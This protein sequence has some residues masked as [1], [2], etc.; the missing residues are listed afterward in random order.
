MDFGLPQQVKEAKE[1]TAEI[2]EEAYEPIEGK[3]LSGGLDGGFSLEV[4]LDIKKKII[5]AGLW[6]VEVPKSGAQGLGFLGRVAIEERVGGTIL[7]SIDLGGNGDL[8]IWIGSSAREHVKQY[9][10][11]VVEGIKDYEVIC[12]EPNIKDD[13]SNIEVKARETN[14]AINLEGERSIISTAHKKT[15]FIILLASLKENGEEKPVFYLVEP[16][17]K[18]LIISSERNLPLGFSMVKMSFDQCKIPAKN[19]LIKEEQV[20]GIIK[21]REC[22]RN[23]ILAARS[24]GAA[25]RCIQMT[26][27]YFKS[28]DRLNRHQAIQALLADSVVE[29]HAARLLTYTRA[30]EVDDGKYDFVMNCISK[31]FSSEAATSGIEKMIQ[32]WADQGYSNELPFET[33]FR[34]V[35]LYR[36]IDRPSEVY[37]KHIAYGLMDRAMP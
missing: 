33:L 11:P 29:M 1:K 31:V 36:I 4:L 5:E 28:N 13:I 32:I 21:N 25:W 23:M 15:D 9:L 6:A 26:T 16:R 17:E 34:I 3:L 19:R 10:E 35:R 27:E 30:Q 24:L 8:L 14:G 7:P 37:R 12:L 22:L 20:L 2:L 18:G